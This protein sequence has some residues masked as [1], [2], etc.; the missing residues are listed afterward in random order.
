MQS[1]SAWGVMVVERTKERR[2]WGKM[3]CSEPEIFEEHHRTL[4]YSSMY[5]TK[6]LQVRYT[7]GKAIDKGRR[8]I[9]CFPGSGVSEERRHWLAGADRNLVSCR[10][11]RFYQ[12]GS[13]SLA[14]GKGLL[15]DIFYFLT[16]KQI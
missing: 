9:P 8:Q 16:T 13:K 5:D 14:A 1:M 11:V 2:A 4:H 15:Y 12:A 7:I 10:W 3:Y 6:E